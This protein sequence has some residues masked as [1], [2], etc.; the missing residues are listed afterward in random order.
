MAGDEQKVLAAGCDDYLPSIVDLSA[1][2]TKMERACSIDSEACRDASSRGRVR[3]PCGGPEGTMPGVARAAAVARGPPMTRGPR[4]RIAIPLLAL[5]IA[6]LSLS[7][8]P[9]RASA[10]VWRRTWVRGSPS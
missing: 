4:A 7:A 3:R 6:S 9:P 5:A 8:D 1:V 10:G 2:R